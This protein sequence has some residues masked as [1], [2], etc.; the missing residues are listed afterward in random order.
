MEIQS[1]IENFT[2]VV[3]VTGK[4]D[5]LTAPAYQEKLNQLIADGTIAFVVDLE[6]LN[7]ISSAGL[8]G[9]LATAKALKGK[10]GQVRF[11]NVKGTVKEVFEMSGFGSI[12]QTHDSVTAALNAIG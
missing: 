1:R 6:G 3:T 5:A 8:R 9:I 10:G 7:Y 11:A 2:A 12:F 4:M